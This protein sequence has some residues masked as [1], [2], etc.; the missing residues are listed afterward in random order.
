MTDIRRTATA[1]RGLR[2]EH[3]T[4]ILDDG[5]SDAVRDL[6]ADLVV[7]AGDPDALADRLA[8]GLDGVRP[9]AQDCRAHAERFSWG[10][11]AARHAALYRAVA[12]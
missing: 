6:A 1:A 5:R 8:A 10:V 11:A 3:S 2:G 7:S 9:S 12:A 4:W